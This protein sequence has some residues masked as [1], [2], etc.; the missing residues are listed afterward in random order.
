MPGFLSLELRGQRVHQLELG[1][2][3]EYFEVFE[4]A[5][6]APLEQEARVAT[7]P[8][9]DSSKRIHPWSPH[10]GCTTDLKSL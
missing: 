10:V 5:I 9:S 6:S 7:A 2:G 3:F 1:V 8:V 4:H